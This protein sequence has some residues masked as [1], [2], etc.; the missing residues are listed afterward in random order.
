MKDLFGQ[1]ILDYQQ[2]QYT[3]DLKTETSI[4]E[5]DVLPLP[6]LFRDYAQMPLLE[7]Q[8]LQMA[9]GR[10][11]DVGCGAGSHALYLQNERGL[12]VT[13]IDLSA[14]AIEVCQLR[15]IRSARVQNVLDTSEKYDTLLLLMNGAG[16]CGRLKKM[17]AFFAHLKTLLNEGGQILTDSSDIIYM[18]DQNPDGSY[19]VPLYGDYYGELEYIVKY[20]GKREKPF[21]WL[22]VD[23]NTLQNVAHAVGLQC[24]LVAQGEHYDYLA[25]LF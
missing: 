4:S 25:R 12:E 23:Y 2:G 18:F 19:D 9:R 24:E 16:M 22:Y 20:K 3:E 21:N 14:K 17:P 10:V 13:A 6:Y 5:E 8:A 7:Q 11:L 1:A 15:G